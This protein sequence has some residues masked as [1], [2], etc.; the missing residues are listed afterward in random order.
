MTCKVFANTQF[1]KTKKKFPQKTPENM[2]YN[3]KTRY[4][5]LFKKK[6]NVSLVSSDFFI[7]YCAAFVRDSSC[8]TFQFL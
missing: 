6:K 4:C 3:Y 2:P 7:C 8:P 1:L 5:N